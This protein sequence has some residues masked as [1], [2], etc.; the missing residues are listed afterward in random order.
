MSQHA[1]GELEW[2]CNEIDSFRIEIDM[3]MSDCIL[4]IL[5][6]FLADFNAELINR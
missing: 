3:M 4:S 2:E 5:F 1:V 6:F